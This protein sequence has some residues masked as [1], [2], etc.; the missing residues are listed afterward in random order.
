VLNI[1]RSRATMDCASIF[2][3]GAEDVPKVFDISAAGCAK[4]HITADGCD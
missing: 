1:S 3:S 4:A 2:T